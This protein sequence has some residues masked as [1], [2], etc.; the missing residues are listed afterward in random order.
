MDSYD[1]EISEALLAIEAELRF[2]SLWESEPPPAA[3]LLSKQPFCCDT[4]MFPQWVQW[5]LL[6]R[7]WTIIDQGGPYPARCGIYVYAE[8]W[9]M[10]QGADCLTLLQLIK[11]FDTLIEGRLSNGLH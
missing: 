1:R 10:H 3:D 4:L 8:E 6:P 11:Q 5:I 2:L 7:M 9:A